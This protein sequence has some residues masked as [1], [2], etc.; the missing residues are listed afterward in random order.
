MKRGGLRWLFSLIYTMKTTVMG[1]KSY[2]KSDCH[3]IGLCILTD[4]RKV[5]AVA[6]W[7]FPYRL[8]AEQ[9]AEKEELQKAAPARPEGYNKELE[10]DFSKVRDKLQ[11]KWVDD[12]KDFGK[13][14]PPI[15]VDPSI[16][17]PAPLTTSTIVLLGLAV[18]PTHQRLGLG[19]LLI[20]G[21]LAIADEAGARIYLESSAVGASLY[22]KHGFR[23][24]DDILID[25]RPYGGTGIESAKCMMREPGGR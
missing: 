12:S 7:Q 17:D 14:K 6:R 18:S 8:S 4:V 13:S 15:Y 5:V 21:G 3:H 19:S 24:V 22:L 25:M 23:Q 2:Q 10:E 16:K 20:R 1:L 11:E 9:K